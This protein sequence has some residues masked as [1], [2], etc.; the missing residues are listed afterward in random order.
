MVSSYRMF[1]I[2]VME[3]NLAAPP[4]AYALERGMVRVLD[5]SGPAAVREVSLL[6]FEGARMTWRSAGCARTVSRNS[7]VRPW[8]QICGCWPTRE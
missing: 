7:S 3:L 1:F 2:R 6:A 8:I 4:F 5:V